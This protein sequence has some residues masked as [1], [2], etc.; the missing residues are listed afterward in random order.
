MKA[1]HFAYDLPPELIAQHPLP[2][3]RDARLLHLPAKGPPVHRRFI[4]FPGLL[5]PGEVLVLNETR[6]LPARLHVARE[7]GGLVEILLLEERGGV[8]RAMAKP[9]RRMRPNEILMGAGGAFRLRVLERAG[10]DVQVEFV[11]STALE[12][13]ER[14]GEVPLP[15]YLRRAAEPEDR[16]R[17]QTVFARVAGAVA[18]PTAGLHFDAEMLE[19]LRLRGVE[20]ASILLHVGAG[21]FRP[22]PE[23]DVD[24]TQ[25]HLDPER[26]EVSEETAG[27]LQRA[28]ERGSRIVACGTTVARAL[29][30]FARG[31]GRGTTSLFIYPP[32]EFKMV[33]ALLTNFHLPRSSLL[34]LVAAFAGRERILSAY[35][36]A[37]REKYRFYS[38][39]DATFLEQPA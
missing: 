3:R 9:A 38:Y 7:S 2:R 8:W 19:E 10:T 35:E 6:V 15:P 32:F 12:I 30:T 37:V 39:G 27:I 11:D 23:E 22:L 26:F 36:E 1:S 16:E 21:T 31:E 20:I 5:S 25:V 17:Y 34:C 29:E 33:G 13:L 14:F 28:K 24:L 18:A 4:D